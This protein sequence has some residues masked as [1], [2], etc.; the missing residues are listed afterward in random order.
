MLVKTKE[1]KETLFKD[2]KIGQ[3]FR[4]NNNESIFVKIYFEDDYICCPECEEDININNEKGEVYAVEL[5]SGLVY[6]FDPRSI[7]EIIRGAFV[8]D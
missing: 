1:R 5:D 3:V 7:V 8:E 2:I 4:D 6:E